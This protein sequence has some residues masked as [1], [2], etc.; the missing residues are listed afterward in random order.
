MSGVHTQ[1]NINC[2]GYS[3]APSVPCIIISLFYGLK[4]GGDK[5]N[6]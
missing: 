6:R 2:K 4:K 5:K 1:P 3:C